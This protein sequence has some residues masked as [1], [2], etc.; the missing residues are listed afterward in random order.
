M[1][2]VL[3]TVLVQSSSTCTT[4][5]VS[6][7]SSDVIDVRTAIPMVMG[8]NIGTSMT[9]TLVSL[10]HATDAKQFERAFS[11]A[12]VHDCFNWLAVI[13]LLTIEVLTGYLFYVTEF[14]TQSINITSSS[15]AGG[16]KLNLLK[17]ITKPLTKQVVQIDKHVLECWSLNNCQNDPRIELYENKTRLLKIFCKSAD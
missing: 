1:I 4:V 13:V 7:V 15:S 6:L 9:S 17:S 5:I 11:A 16:G 2:G 10:T 14:I 3:F 12:T 8:A